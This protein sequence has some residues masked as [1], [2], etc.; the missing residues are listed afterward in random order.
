METNEIPIDSQP[1]SNKTNEPSEPQTHTERKQAILT[2]FE[3]KRIQDF[4]PNILG[5]EE[6]QELLKKI[7]TA[8]ENSSDNG[9]N[10]V[11]KELA[12]FIDRN[13]YIFP[14]FSHGTSSDGL[15]NIARAGIYPAE[16]AR[17]IYQ[18]D[19]TMQTL[20]EGE[21]GGREGAIWN[22]SAGVGQGGLG[23]ALA[24]AD[25]IE[26]PNW[27][28]NY[29]TT[30]QTQS[31]I[32][33]CKAHLEQYADPFIKDKLVRLQTAQRRMASGIP[34]DFPIV[35]GFNRSLRLTLNNIP[36]SQWGFTRRDLKLSPSGHGSVI[37][38]NHELDSELVFDDL[39]QVMPLE[40]QVIASPNAHIENAMQIIDQEGRR[41]IQLIS[42]EALREL[43]NFGYP[44]IKLAEDATR[45]RIL[46]NLTDKEGMAL[47]ALRLPF[48]RIQPTKQYVDDDEV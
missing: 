27:N 46:T 5:E 47:V 39:D 23:T 26:D 11:L 42:F 28:P 16:I 33:E 9:R 20:G 48:M 1:I 25:V 4:E 29:L 7:Q 8:I 21:R 14:E 40:I 12:T 10:E 44:R 32:N 2:S 24:Y 31:S 18:D 41:D 22:I 43:N 19:V 15:G 34:P 30:E 17:G 13:G 37:G 36:R 6:K 3:E 35:I 38:H 45:N